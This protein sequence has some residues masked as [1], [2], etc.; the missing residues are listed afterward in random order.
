MSATS[1]SVF[2]CVLFGVIGFSPVA[3][4]VL[5]KF[6]YA[7]AP[8]VPVAFAVCAFI[9]SSSR[10]FKQ[11]ALLLLSVC[12]GVTLTDLVARP[13]FLHLSSA[14]PA[15]RY[16]Y[17]W[18]PLPLLQRYVASVNF[19]GSTYGDLA[20]ASTK[21][22]WREWH[23]IRFITDEYGF[24]NETFHPGFEARPLDVIVLG[25]SFGVAASTTQEETLSSVLA[26]DYGLSVYNLSVS[27]EGPRHQ[28]A[29]LVLEGPRL[30]TR[31]G[32]DVL[33]L[34]FGGNDLDDPYNVELENPKPGNPALLTTIATA[35]RDFRARSPVRRLLAR[36]DT[37]FILER[38]FVDG[39]RMLFNDY[40]AQRR[41]R[42]A[43]DIMQHP[44]FEALKTTMTAMQ[45]LTGQRGLHVS[46]AVV[47]S[48]EEVYAWVLDGAPPWSTS[49]EP[50]GFSKVLNRLSEE[51][52]FYFIDLKPTLLE[53]AR[54]EYEKS[55]GLIWWA[56]DTHWNGQGQRAAARVIY[57]NLLAPQRLTDERLRGK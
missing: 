48:K 18:P 37:S 20:S 15:E 55:A 34:I 16:I 42:T 23:K 30:K 7:L 13:V 27:R 44:N 46:V 24:R 54:Q 36:I 39:R 21:P 1:R 57:Q 31:E 17:R 33:W 50:S 8:V 29:N 40:Y 4:G 14:R 47:P 28:Y 51:R 49:P 19:E 56:D 3:I 2:Y 32:A 5:D 10:R 41:S 22:E 26:R 6:P 12:L 35:Y 11:I 53:E 43:Y 45:K 38:K 52:G 25:D 9:W